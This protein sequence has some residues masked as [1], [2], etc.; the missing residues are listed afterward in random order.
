MAFHTIYFRALISYSTAFNWEFS[1][2]VFSVYYVF[3]SQ[4]GEEY[5]CLITHTRL[6][7]IRNSY[8]DA[9]LIDAKT[10]SCL[11]TIQKPFNQFYTYQ[12][13]VTFSLLIIHLK[14]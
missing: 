5:Q 1:F 13:I 14:Y 11:I 8:S 10:F 3:Y 6:R 2:C 9:L 4:Q 12:Q 7:L